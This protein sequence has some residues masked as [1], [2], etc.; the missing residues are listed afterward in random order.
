MEVNI[1]IA[2]GAGFIL[3]LFVMGIVALTGRSKA[4][5]FAS[6]LLNQ[7]QS[8]RIKDL[9]AIIERLKE[10]F[11]AI[12]YEALNK[13]TTHFLQIANETLKNQTYQ[14]EQNL[15]TKKRL[16]DQTL[17]AMGK[18]MAK[19]QEV[20]NQLEKDREQK[21]GELTNQL[22]VTT[23]QTA[24][25]QNVAED[26][27]AALSNTKVRGQWGE[28][29]AEDV[30]QMVGFSEGIN[31]LK[32]KETASGSRPDYT[33]LLP[34]NLKVNMDVKFPLNNY[35]QYIQAAPDYQ[36]GYKQQFL[37]DV[38]DRIIEVT[39]RDYINPEDHTLDYVLLFIPNE[40]IYN[41]INES[42]SNLMNLA[43]KNRVLLCSPLTLFAFLAVIRQAVENFNL[44]QATSQILSLMGS[45]HKQWEA[46]CGTLDRI[47]R[48]ID[49]AQKEYQTLSF[50]RR[51]QLEK[52]LHM[53]EELRKERGLPI[54]TFEAE[55]DGAEKE[56]E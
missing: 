7:A 24:K 34:K 16:I 42:D 50:T 37:K 22:K 47:G 23:E 52:P 11:A 2:F 39:S 12:S 10:P 51:N 17:E 56:V 30:L 14:G 40:Q 32:Q 13:N 38:K 5:Q 25:L 28:R 6:E 35:L 45:F 53:I 46:F 36:A 44:E 15:E 49:E 21:F 43:L 55:N 26:L 27:R 41:F 31:Y 33:F 1:I 4:N 9:E 18:E 29:M 48:R 3:G 19:V 8:Q 54:D 20:V